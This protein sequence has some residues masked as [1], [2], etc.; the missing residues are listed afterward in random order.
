ML[1]F[2]KLVDETQMV[3][4]REHAA[5]DILYKFL[6]FLPFRAIYFRSFHYET[7]C[8]RKKDCF[9]S[10]TPHFFGPSYFEATLA[11]VILVSCEKHY[12]VGDFNRIP[13]Y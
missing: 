7:P 5:R 1:L 13:K 3:N 12:R 4:P 6:F 10:G 2:L 11:A 9:F 8:I